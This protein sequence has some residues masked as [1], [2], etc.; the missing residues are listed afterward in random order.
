[1]TQYNSLNVTLSNS[2]LKNLELATKNETEVVVRLS[3]NMIG[4]SNDEANFPHKLLWTNRKVANL[5]KA[6]ENYL[7]ADIKLSKTLVSKIVQLGFL[8]KLHGPLRKT[9]LLLMTNVPEPLAKSVL[10]S[11]RL[12]TAEAGIH[13]QVLV[14][15]ANINKYF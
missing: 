15:G 5:C 13:K 2:H 11:L 7:S 3:S 10:I 1:M 9:G 4:N 12:T 14:S 6:F 8:G